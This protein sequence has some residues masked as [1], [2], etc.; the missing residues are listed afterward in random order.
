MMGSFRTF[1]RE[2]ARSR[3]IDDPQEKFAM[4]CYIHFGEQEPGSI[5]CETCL[6]FKEKNCPGENRR[7][8][9]CLL[10]MSDHAGTSIMETSGF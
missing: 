3:R 4:I 1:R 6:D 8:D 7:G 9:D 2:A 5:S 10:C